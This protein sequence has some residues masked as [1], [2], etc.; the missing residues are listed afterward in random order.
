MENFK[1]TYLKHCSK[2]F[3]RNP[4]VKVVTEN[5]GNLLNLKKCSLYLQLWYEDYTSVEHVFRCYNIFKLVTQKGTSVEY[6]GDEK[7]EQIDFYRESYWEKSGTF[8]ISRKNYL[9]Q[10]FSNINSKFVCYDIDEEN[11]RNKWR[12]FT[13]LQLLTND[14]HYS[15]FY[16][17]WSNLE[18]YET[19]R[20]ILLKV[21]PN[22]DVVDK[23]GAMY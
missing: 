22:K 15:Y 5:V 13:L 11:D 9:K 1:I 14:E 18:D 3:E 12:S 2:N 7:E 23:I 20:N 6:M 8:R 16:K 19:I 17:Y 4:E 10:L 21:I